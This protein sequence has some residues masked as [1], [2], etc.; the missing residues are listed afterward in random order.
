MN[1]FIQYIYMRY[2]IDLSRAYK[3][4][5][6][7]IMNLTKPTENGVKY[8]Q[9][10]DNILMEYVYVCDRYVSNSGTDLDDD[11]LAVDTNGD[12]MN[13]YGHSPVSTYRIA[14]NGYVN[15]LYFMNDESS[16]ALTN[17]SMLNTVLPVRKDQSKWVETK[18]VDGKYYSRYDTKWSDIDPISGESSINMIPTAPDGEYVPYDIVRFYFQ[19]GYH[20]EYDGFIFNIYTR[21]INNEYVNL[22]CAMHENR[23]NFRMLS[24]PLWFADKLYTNYIEFRVP[25]TAY[26]SSDVIGGNTSSMDVNRWGGSGNYDRKNPDPETLPYFLTHSIGF[27]NNPAIGI[28]LHAVTGYTMDR[29]FKVYK[30]TMLTSTLFP[31]KDAYERLTAS[32]RPA[33]DGDYYKLYAYYENDPSNPIYDE[34][35]LY[36]Y[37]QHFNNTFTVIHIIT[38]SE[39]YTDEANNTVTDTQIPITYIQ[40]WDNLESMYEANES[41]EILFRPV[42]KHTSRMLSD[43]DGARISYVVRITNDRDNTT[44]IKSASCS[45][46]RPRRFGLNMVNANIGSVNDV[47][48]YNRV[49]SGPVLRVNTVTHPLGSVSSEQAPVQVNTYVTS[50]FI[51]RRNIKIRVSPVRIEEVE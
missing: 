35:S 4:N 29:E 28:D 21:N 16:S 3:Y 18:K 39:T 33:S 49:E 37:L 25:S 45:I 51:D 27:Y 9:L 2:I 40:S 48:V 50:S 20:S 10:T 44:I 47:R 11:V 32:V 15:E 41:P 38:V 36:E 8:L 7:I 12:F 14:R 31:N 1:L 34:L 42:L 13:T 46:I 6:A 26:F 5:K 23:D 17:N 22:L 30:S 43:G 24:E 19:S